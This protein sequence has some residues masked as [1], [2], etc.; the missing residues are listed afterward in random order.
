M[1]ATPETFFQQGNHMTTTPIEPTALERMTA[2]DEQLEQEH[3]GWMTGQAMTDITPDDRQWAYIMLVAAH[4]I[5]P[6]NKD[7]ILA[8]DWDNTDE[9]QFIAR[10]RQAA[11]A[12]VIA[13]ATSDEAVERA[14]RAIV[15]RNWPSLAET[16]IDEM[17][18]AQ[19]A[20]AKA[21]LTAALTERKS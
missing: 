5:Y 1:N 16:D 7:A 8:G 17:W 11:I 19:A 15:R 12:S 6:H 3:P 2:L 10:H 13:H 20:N 18:D 21:A 4:K 14:A 9:V